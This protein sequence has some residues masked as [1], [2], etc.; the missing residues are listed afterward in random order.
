MKILIIDK[1]ETSSAKLESMI[2]KAEGETE[3]FSDVFRALIRLNENPQP[4]LMI[5]DINLN[6]IDGFQLI[7]KINED[8]SNAQIPKIIYTEYNRL[9][10]H[11]QAK[12]LG[13]V[14]FFNKKESPEVLLPLIHTV[15]QRLE[16][17]N[18]LKSKQSSLS[19]LL[20]EICLPDI[21]QIIHLSRKTG[22]LYL[23]QMNKQATIHIR[24][25]E[26]FAVFSNEAEGEA[27]LYDLLSWQDG[28]FRFQ[29]DVQEDI[30]GNFTAGF[31]SALLDG[32]KFIDELEDRLRLV[33]VRRNQVIEG[34]VNP[35]LWYYLSLIDNQH[36]LAELIAAN[37]LNRNIAV[38]NYLQLERTKKCKLV[39][40]VPA[41]DWPGDTPAAK[42]DNLKILIVDDSRLMLNALSQSLR[43]VAPGVEL[44]EAQSGA[45]ALQLLKTFHPNVITLDVQMPGMDGLTTLKHI[46]LS[47]PTP[48]VML[49]AFTRDG[50]LTTFEALRFGAVDF[51]TKPVQQT[52]DELELQRQ[53]LFSKIK[54][55]STINIRGLR[56][57]QLRK[58]KRRSGPEIITANRNLLLIAS[59]SG[60]YP[61]L[62]Q[63]LSQIDGDIAVPIVVLQYIAEEHLPVF[64]N[65]LAK[66]TELRYRMAESLQ[67]LENGVCYFIPQ[68]QY[69]SF[70][71][72]HS[73]LQLICNARP[74]GSDLKQNLNIAMFSAS[75]T[76]T[77]R[78][79]GVLLAGSET[80]GA[81]GLTEIRRQGGYT[82]VQDP[83]TGLHSTSVT[84]ALRQNAAMEVFPINCLG[85]KIYD[86]VMAELF[87][88]MEKVRPELTSHRRLNGEKIMQEPI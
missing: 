77:D 84:A 80:D 1:D 15:K 9:R 47:H 69:S 2:S 81:D 20:T 39:E 12:A 28:S 59:P 14:D 33:P 55:A 43:T 37:N 4:D 85:S 78:V 56:H 19:G 86:N 83:S 49:S 72:N 25:G 71:L 27:A 13:V 82:V 87:R 36:T 22:V 16:E 46:M 65:Y 10:D 50:A 53:E 31:H 66:Y 24:Q 44:Q 67:T 75:E 40:Q 74:F 30:A 61:A 64:I 3:I 58:T 18:R 60:N 73:V 8:K 70:S 38:F 7:Q 11:E 63:L 54:L 41:A 32:T 6:G 29:S 52:Q 35:T 17:A 51:F 76:A 5:I 21:L 57:I 79:I 68:S 45:E 48:V 34:D 88:E 26:I 62:L 42:N 23:Q